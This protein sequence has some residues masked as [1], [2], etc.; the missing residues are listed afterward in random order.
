MFQKNDVSAKY[1]AS[2]NN[3]LQSFLK[4]EQSWRSTKIYRRNTFG[5]KIP[6]Y[7]EAAGVISEHVAG[8]ISFLKRKMV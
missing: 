2:V 5:G 7:E 3:E 6:S 1:L 4:T 8:G